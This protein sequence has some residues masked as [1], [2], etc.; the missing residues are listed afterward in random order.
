MQE[1]R[2][3]FSTNDW[4]LYPPIVLFVDVGSLGGNNS[5]DGEPKTKQRQASRFKDS[6]GFGQKITGMKVTVQLLFWC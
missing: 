4:S 3:I 2:W 6:W 5:K 1:N